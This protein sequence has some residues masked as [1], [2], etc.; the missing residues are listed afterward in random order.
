VE[1]TCFARSMPMVIV[2]MGDFLFALIA[3][4]PRF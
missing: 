3:T 2:P 4:S 1:N